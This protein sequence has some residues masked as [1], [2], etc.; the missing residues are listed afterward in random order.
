MGFRE[1]LQVENCT[2]NNDEYYIVYDKYGG[3]L[4]YIDV[5]DENK[6]KDEYLRGVTCFVVNENNE[7]LVETRAKTQLTPGKKDLVSGHVNGN[8]ISIQSMKRELAEEVGIKVAANKI[9]IAGKMPLSFANKGGIRNFFITFCYIKVKNPKLMCQED[10]VKSL[11]WIPIEDV[12]N[13][14]KNGKT[15]F[16]KQGNG[17]NYENIF[18][19]VRESCTKCSHHNIE[20]DLI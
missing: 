17:V 3:F 5:K 12:F 19:T 8:E 16:P 18:N 14:I 15:K 4:R 6:I 7:V 1:S 2:K 13:M 10:E 20:K 9:C 11:E